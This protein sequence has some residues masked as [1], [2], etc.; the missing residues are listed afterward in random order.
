MIAAGR[1]RH[2]AIDSID[3]CL[4]QRLAVH[5]SDLHCLRLL[6]RGPATPKE[7]ATPIGLTSGSTT[8]LVNRLEGAGFVERCRSASNRRC[9]KVAIVPI[10]PGE[11][12][13][14]LAEIELAVSVDFGGEEAN[15]FAESARIPNALA[16]ILPRCS[17]RLGH[18][19]G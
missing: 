10:R 17:D 5:R 14:I 12:R 2:E 1:Q 15:A 19:P 11:L 7:V 18:S 8:A 4:A 16:I 13:A 3:A 9:I 6:E